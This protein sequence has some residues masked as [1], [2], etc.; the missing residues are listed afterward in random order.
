MDLKEDNLLILDNI[1]KDDEKYI[2]KFVDKK[3]INEISFSEIE[4]SSDE[5]ISSPNKITK[6]YLDKKENLK[7][8]KNFVKTLN[9]IIIQKDKFDLIEKV[10]LHPSFQ[11]ILNEIRES[12]VLINACKKENIEA[13]QWLITMNINF[14]IQDKNGMTALMYAAENPKLLFL[15][16]YIILNHSE[17]VNITDNNDENALFHAI[18]N[19]DSFKIILNS[20]INFNHI[21]LNKETVLILCCKKDLMDQVRALALTS[22]VN[23]NIIDNEGRTGPMYLV[24]NGRYHEFQ[25]LTGC[26]IDLDYRN[27]KNETILSTLIQCIYKPKEELKKDY[28]IPYFKIIMILVQMDCDFNIT[29]DEE[30]NTPLM[31][32]IMIENIYTVHYI[33]TFCRN[34]NVSIKNKKGESAFSLSLKLQNQSLIEI[35]M[36][37]QSFDFSFFDSNNN[38]LLMLYS[39]VNNT[40]IIKKILTKL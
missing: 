27:E 14:S 1:I 10:L 6:I 37:H 23:T 25:L 16:Q 15:V 38:N 39:I 20:D 35:L 17:C 30:G 13:I 4:D 2:N 34:L 5:K 28:I 40:E 26:D 29:I 24:K 21:N 19:I 31:F 12:E 11:F 8:I 32:F 22:M 7:D 3:V 18:N 9:E 33:V 36:N